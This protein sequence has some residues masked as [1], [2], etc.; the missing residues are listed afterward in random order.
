MSEPHQIPS[1]E[2]YCPDQTNFL[3]CIRA[4][5]NHISKRCR[6]TKHHRS[7]CSPLS[8]HAHGY[9]QLVRANDIV[10]KIMDG[11]PDDVRTIL[12]RRPFSV[13]DLDAP[14]N[15]SDEDHHWGV[16][17]LASKDSGGR[18]GV[19]IGSN[20]SAVG[21]GGRLKEHRSIIRGKNSVDQHR[22]LYRCMSPRGTIMTPKSIAV[23]SQEADLEPAVRIAEGIIM[24]YLNTFRTPQKRPGRIWKQ[25]ET[26]DHSAHKFIRTMRRR[27]VVKRL[28]LQ[29]ELLPD[30]YE[31]ALNRGRALKQ[32]DTGPVI[33]NHKSSFT[34]SSQ[35]T[36]PSSQ[37]KK[38]QSYPF[39]F[40]SVFFPRV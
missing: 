20:T 39:V 27:L 16:Y 4:M 28:R 38:Q 30:L 5:V 22:D 6:S 3:L 40:L 14:P 15:L 11:I 12:G 29:E 9:F 19:Y 17:A 21:V 18:R 32:L 37:E 10:T 34:E 35:L 23:F 26:R 1:Q 7:N 13:V 8:Q 31:H 24:A 25:V 33:R 2:S 36:I